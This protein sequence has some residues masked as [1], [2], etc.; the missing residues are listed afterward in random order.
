M[1]IKLFEPK[2]ALNQEE[3][4]LLTQE[5]ASGCGAKAV[6]PDVKT[7]KRALD[8]IRADFADDFQRISDLL[9]TP[10][11]C[12]AFK[13]LVPAYKGMEK[14]SERFSELLTIGLMCL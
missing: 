6:I 3:L 14:G 5:I 12:S 8:K 13:Q 1:A 9:R 4:A 7:R 10:I 11:I 2:V